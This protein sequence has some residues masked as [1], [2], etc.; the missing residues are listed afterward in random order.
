M[1]NL[2]GLLFELSSAERMNMLNSL[3][4]ERLKLSH[5]AKRLDMTVTETSRH[6]QRLSD[7]HSS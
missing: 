4:N 3:R 5:L 6:L 7:S 2:C 1:E